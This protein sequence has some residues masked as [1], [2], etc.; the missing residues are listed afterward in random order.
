MKRDLYAFS[1][2]FPITLLLSACRPDM[3]STLEPEGFPEP[4]ISTLAATPDLPA[5][6]SIQL[7]TT[8][9]NLL[10]NH[11]IQGSLDLPNA[12]T[13]DIPLDGTPVWLTSAPFGDGALFAV[14][15]ENG[16]TQA[17]AVTGQTHEPIEISPAQL[18]AGMPPLLAVLDGEAQLT[19]PPQDASL[20]TNPLLVADRLVYIAANGDLVLSDSTSQNRLPVNALLDAR[21]L[22]DERNRLLLLSGPTNRYK[23][24]VLGDELEASGITLIETAPELRV[25]RNIPIEAP[26][27]VEGI[28]PIWADLDEDGQREIVV[29]LSN[30]Q[31][32]ARIAVFREDGS[33]L[34]ESPPIGQGYRWR[35]QVAVAQFQPDQPP[36]I[37][38][39]R[40]P[41]IGGVVE[42][43]QLIAGRLEPVRETGGF[44]AHSLGSRNLDSAVAGDF[45]NDGIAELLAPEQSHTALGIIAFD[46]TLATTPLDGI[47]TSNLSVTNNEGK[48]FIG[49]GTPGNL[50]IW[51]P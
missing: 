32:G 10:G 3:Q 26:D 38:S 49:A 12:S 42:F 13:T 16:Q 46:G 31:G 45:N 17:F 14:V 28:S 15:L 11:L 6:E 25:I 19:A 5:V 41:H 18:P 48:I 34:A 51:S 8:Q 39:I 47:L 23:H 43:F 35:H 36:L 37:V 24:G 22:L 33:L 20:L 44:S 30:N 29:T 4:T 27:V 40:T 21:L 2:L 9:N 7:Y 50:R 1:I